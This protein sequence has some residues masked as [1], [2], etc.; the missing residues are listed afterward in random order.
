MTFFFF[1][2]CHDESYNVSGCSYYLSAFEKSCVEAQDLI[3]LSE[4]WVYLEQLIT[5][6][7]TTKF[8]RAIKTKSF[9]LFTFSF[10]RKQ[11]LTL[12][13]SYDVTHL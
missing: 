12:L 7:M 10:L 2:L 13:N 1:F 6:S 4:N 11:I 5:L 3:S 8:I 9:R